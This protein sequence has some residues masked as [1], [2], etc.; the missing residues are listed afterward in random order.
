VRIINKKAEDRLSIDFGGEEPMKK[1]LAVGCILVLASTASAQN[2]FR[3]TLDQAIAKAK[4]ENKLVL[5]DFYSA[6]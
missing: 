5:L 3:G 2:W 6:G 1:A 4:T